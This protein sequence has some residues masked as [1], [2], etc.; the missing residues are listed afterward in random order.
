MLLCRPIGCR[1]VDIDRS[2]LKEL[3]AFS[4]PQNCA[5]AF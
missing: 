5:I 2:Y 1:I 4:V 3:F